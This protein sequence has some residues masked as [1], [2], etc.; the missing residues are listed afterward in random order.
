MTHFTKLALLGLALCAASFGNPALAQTSANTSLNITGF[1]LIDLDTND[2]ITPAFYVGSVYNISASYLRDYISNQE[3]FVHYRPDD[4][5]A[6]NTN[7]TL[8][9]LNSG[10]NYSGGLLGNQT[11]F[12]QAGSPGSGSAY[13]Y[14]NLELG[15]A[16]TPNTQLILLGHAS[17]SEAAPDSSN[18][19]P[20][21]ESGTT[22]T[23]RQQW[24]GFVGSFGETTANQSSYNRDF[25]IVFNNGGNM[26][27]GELKMRTWANAAVDTTVPV[28]EP[29]SWAMMLLGLGALGVV[30]R[31]RNR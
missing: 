6:H 28:P 20:H 8:N 2:G 10:G 22:L 7:N 3:S 12:A 17:A 21:Q 27:Q 16:L 26:F 31:R 18:R 15:F 4:L 29:E 23:L 1:Q 11:A 24:G 30:A 14:A 19:A 13:G 9:N 5:S 25:S